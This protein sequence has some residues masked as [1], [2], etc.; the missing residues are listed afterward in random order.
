MMK[1]PV[2]ATMS[3]SDMTPRHLKARLPGAE[4]VTFGNEHTRWTVEGNL[5]QR[6]LWES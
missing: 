3:I 2:E 1:L 6:N 5:D 4:G